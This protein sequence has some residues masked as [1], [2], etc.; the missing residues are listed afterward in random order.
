MNVLNRP[1]VHLYF[2]I[3]MDVGKTTQHGHDCR[4]HTGKVFN[5]GCRGKKI[6][7]VIEPLLLRVLEQL[8]ECNT[9]T[10]LENGLGWKQKKNRH[11]PTEKIEW[12]DCQEKIQSLEAER[13]AYETSAVQKSMCNAQCISQRTLIEELEKL[14]E[15]VLN[16]IAAA[17]KRL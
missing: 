9:N 16:R 11:Q 7:F 17:T 10:H 2:H 3:C 13:R 1:E 12:N 15:D 6:F 8:Q 14:N 4:V 5:V